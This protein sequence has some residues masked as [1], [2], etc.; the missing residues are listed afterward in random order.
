MPRPARRAHRL[1]M[2]LVNIERF[3]DTFLAHGD[4]PGF[5]EKKRYKD[6]LAHRDFV[7]K[8][9]DKEAKKEPEK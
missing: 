8:E 4:G 7:I 9:Y 3:F 2:E 5:K 1:A 6:L